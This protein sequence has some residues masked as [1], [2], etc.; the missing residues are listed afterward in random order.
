MKRIIAVLLCLV[1]ALMAT[2]CS[3]L[4]GGSGGSY[5]K[6]PQTVTVHYYEEKTKTYTS[7]SGANTLETNFIAP[8]GQVIKGLFD[9]AGIQY[10]GYDCIIDLKSNPKLPSDLYA[11]YEDVDIS[12]LQ[13]S[14]LIVNDEDPTKISFYSTSSTRFTF[15][16]TDPDDQKFIAACL[17]NPYADVVF[18]VT[19]YGKGLGN[20]NY[21]DFFSK[22]WVGE[23]VIG[24]YT[25]EDFDSGTSYT[26]YTY[27]CRIKAKQLINQNYQFVLQNSARYGYEDYTIKNCRIDIAFDFE[28]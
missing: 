25:T 9:D 5:S 2:S 10:A 20:D 28:S 24:S 6:E 17:C 7:E 26:K 21:N 13:E 8:A 18:T 22:L 16:A 27:T 15:V 12:Y 4:G 3:F 14:P 23:D 11:E 19:F 1:L